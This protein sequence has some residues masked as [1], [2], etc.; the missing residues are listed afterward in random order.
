MLLESGTPSVPYIRQWLARSGYVAWHAADISDAMEELLD[1]TVRVR[2][3]VVLLEVQTLPQCFETLQAAFSMSA[4]QEVTVFGLM[5]T[6]SEAPA[7][8]FFAKNLEELRSLIMTEH[9]LPVS[10]AA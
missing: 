4:N 8:R 7:G 9:S 5:G 10:R 3:D 1:F 2:P 6:T